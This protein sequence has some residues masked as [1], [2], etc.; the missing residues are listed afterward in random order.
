MNK[1]I[2]NF[3]EVCFAIIFIDGKHGAYNSMNINKLITVGNSH[4]LL[5]DNLFLFIDNEILSSLNE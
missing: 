2:A 1:L 5:K 4:K 3:H